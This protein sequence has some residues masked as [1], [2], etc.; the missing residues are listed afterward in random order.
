MHFHVQEADNRLRDLPVDGQA[1]PAPP[2]RQT[3]PSP[4]E[5]SSTIFSPFGLHVCMKLKWL[6][7]GISR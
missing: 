3:K 4:G 1:V 7:S 6:A 5:S 2:S